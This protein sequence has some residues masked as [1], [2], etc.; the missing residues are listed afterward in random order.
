MAR[1]G[2][3]VKQHRH[4]SVLGNAMLGKDTA[5][6]A[7]SNLWGQ[8]VGW[9]GQSGALRPVD[10]KGTLGAVRGGAHGDLRLHVSQGRW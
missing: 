9:V 10:Q 2:K 3:L 1:G 7:E 6:G 4:A 8:L 5:F